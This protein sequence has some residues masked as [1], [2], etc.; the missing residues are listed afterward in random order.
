ML[1]NGKVSCTSNSKH[2]AIKYFWC[3]DRIKKGKI[4]VRHCPTDKMLA[5]YMS[6]RNVLM[7]WQHISTLFDIFS[8][9][10]KGVESNGCLAVKPKNI[11]MTYAKMVRV[12]TAEEAQDRLVGN[13][14]DPIASLIHVDIK[15]K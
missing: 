4:S 9:T 7:G 2:V 10:E 14:G 5:D 8:S 11:K 3:T 12:T 13:G 6:F 1:V 15:K